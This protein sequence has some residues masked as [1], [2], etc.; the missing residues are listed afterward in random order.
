M[1][2]LCNGIL[3]SNSQ[4]PTCLDEHKVQSQA[5]LTYLSR[6]SQVVPSV[7]RITLLVR[8]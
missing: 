2:D 5:F 1:M 7:C 4:V 6:N 8:I 3:E